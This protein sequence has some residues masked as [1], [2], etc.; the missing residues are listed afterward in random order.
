[1]I[2]F[3]YTLSVILLFAFTFV[4]K[5]FSLKTGI[6]LEYPDER[7]NHKKPVPLI[8]G[9]VL[10]LTILALSN[11][12]VYSSSILRDPIFYLV[13]TIGFIDDLFE[14]PYCTKLILQIVVATIYTSINLF[15]LIPDLPLLNK[16]AT[17][18]F[19]VVILNAFNLIDGV[20]GLLLGISIVYSLLNL[21][22]TLAFLL[23]LLIMLNFKEKLFMGD[24]GAFL[25][26]YLLLNRQ[27]VSHNLI[28]LSI[29]FGYPLYEI[30]SSFLRRLL[31]GKN[32]FKPDK[33][34][35]HH[36]GVEK[37]GLLSFLVCAYLL[38]LGFSLISTKKFGIVIY[39][40]I[41]S[42]LFIVQLVHIRRLNK[43]KSVS[44][45]DDSNLEL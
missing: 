16:I 36:I 44:E 5:I 26:A 39:I 42:M 34:H 23:F 13:F 21:D 31:L 4:L 37:L 32:P 41:F 14:I 12:R 33:Y 11:L 38:A 2:S 18:V 30:T 8:G 45:R 20:N 28:N 1:M 3:K 7:K 24:S 15:Y 40:L 35:L 17:A 25:L 27:N 9:T 6:L 10:F 19:F 29:Y 43:F 22:F